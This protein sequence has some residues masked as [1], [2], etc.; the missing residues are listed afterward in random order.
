MTA[1]QPRRGPGT[2]E[3]VYRGVKW[4]RSGA[5]RILWF[6]EGLRRWVVWSPGSDAPPLPEAWRDALVGVGEPEAPR[7]P[8]Y[9]PEAMRSRPKM[10]SPWRITPI[11]I[12]LLVVAIAVYQATRVPRA[13]RRDISNAELLAGRCLA[14]SGG[15]AASPTFSTVPVNCSS[16]LAA[17][18][19]LAVRLPNKGA[20]CPKGTDFTMVLE[21]G[22]EGEPFECLA[23]LHRRR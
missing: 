8:S 11:I 10:T 13:S 15:T 5:G 22:V 6:N 23:A 19:V 1:P 21:P 20:T 17:V 16:P 12:T 18:K 14:R 7:S 9:L 2:E 4:R 3:V